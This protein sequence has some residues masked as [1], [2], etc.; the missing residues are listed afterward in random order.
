[1]QSLSLLFHCSVEYYN[2][3]NDLCCTCRINV[4][5][6]CELLHFVHGEAKKN[7]GEIALH[8]CSAFYF[9]FNNFVVIILCRKQSGF[10]FL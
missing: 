8:L 1:M 9:Q 4:H 6:E 10:F 2:S 7:R 5:R 3:F